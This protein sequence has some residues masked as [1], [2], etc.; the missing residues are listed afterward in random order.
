MIYGLF[1]G[2]LVRSFFEF[3]YSAD[4]RAL[5]RR[6]SF[7]GADWSNDPSCATLCTQLFN[8]F[9][10]WQTRH[11]GLRLGCELLKILR[12]ICKFVGSRVF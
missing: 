5:G 12:L 1:I 4:R 2:G 11:S 10:A 9:A 6:W 3:H 8:I 7:M